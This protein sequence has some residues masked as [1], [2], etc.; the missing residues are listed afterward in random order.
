M[1]TAD[2]LEFDAI[3]A[4]IA[5]DDPA[6][7]PKDF[8]MLR[9]TL[10]ECRT[11]HDPSQY[12]EGTPEHE[13]EKRDANWGKIL[14]EARS[15]LT[16]KCKHILYAVR[17]C[18]ALVMM[19]GFAGVRDG[20]KLCRRLVE[21]C[22]DRMYPKIEEPGDEAARIAQLNWLGDPISGAFYP[23]KVRKTPLFGALSWQSWKDGAGNFEAAVASATTE[24]CQL[25]VDDLEAA[26]HE[27]DSLVSVAESRSPNDVPELG[28][29]S[30]AL[31][32]C[33]VL[34]QQG[35]QKKV[36]SGGGTGGEM[37]VAEGGGAVA[38]GGIPMGAGAS[39][40]QIYEAVMRLADSLERIEPHSPVP[41]LL[42]KIVGL[43]PM[44]FYEL[45]AELTKDQRVL[46]FMKPPEEKPAES[47]W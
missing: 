7:D 10:D 2:L 36:G 8:F 38:A 16:S 6:G 43:G 5:G 46:D 20:M 25:L 13:Q 33:L 11:E 27:L 12:P 23:T 39:R 26:R 17:I 44:R 34:A 9:R 14:Q 29:V 42:K 30:R 4:P 37:M 31:Q 15:A 3:V 22:W 18:E 35:L 41:A 32:D 24:Q 45:V 28:E 21:D 47:S 1:P 19:H 40:E